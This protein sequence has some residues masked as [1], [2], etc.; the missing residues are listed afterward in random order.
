MTSNRPRGRRPGQSDTRQDIL[1]AALTLFYR[2]GY[3]KVS[4]R[5]IARESNVDPALIHHYFDS[6]TDLF[7]QAVLNLDL[8][9]AAE[10][11]TT[12]LEGDPEGIGE[13]AIDVFLRI[14]AAPGA[15]ERF[16]A[17]LRG[18]V[19][20]QQAHRPF[21]EYLATEIFSK[22]A[23]AQGH[24]NAQERGELAVTLI[25]GLVLSRDVMGFSA[26]RRIKTSQLRHATGRAMQ[27]YL[28]ESW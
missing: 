5:A 2:D 21:S 12:V 25:L 26:I 1:T 27:T 19:E 15:K 20:A 11:V 6:K 13:R 4:L 28:V 17:M 24:R 14:W 3:D 9:D 8:P 10:L 7:N 23:K 22:V 18:S 16:A